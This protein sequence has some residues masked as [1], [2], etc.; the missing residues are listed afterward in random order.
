MQKQNFYIQN[1]YLLIITN[2]RDFYSY[3]NRSDLINNEIYRAERLR[4]LHAIRAHL[5]RNSIAVRADNG[6]RKERN[7]G[8]LSWQ[9]EGQAEKR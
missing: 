7:R 3:F 4:K 1:I 8:H 5:G 9:T 6:C 2:I